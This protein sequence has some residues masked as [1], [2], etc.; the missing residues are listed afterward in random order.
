MPRRF[1][2]RTRYISRHR[3]LK[4]AITL[5]LRPN[6]DSIVHRVRELIDDPTRMDEMRLKCRSS[7]AS[8]YGEKAQLEPRASMLSELLSGR[9]SQ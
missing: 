5:R 7:M 1:S 4:D 9:Q 6:V 2:L 3:S 8:I